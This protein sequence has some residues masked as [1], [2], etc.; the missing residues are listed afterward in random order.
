MPVLVAI[1]SSFSCNTCGSPAYEHA[2]LACAIPVF[3]RTVYA[4]EKP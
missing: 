2:K 1:L 3:A 4:G